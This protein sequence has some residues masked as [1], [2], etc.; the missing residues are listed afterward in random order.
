MRISRL[1]FLL[2]IVALMLALI[3]L[4]SVSAQ[5]NPDG[6]PT[7]EMV[8]V[9]GSFQ[10]EL[11][12]SGEWQPECENT[13]L[14]FNADTGLWEG[15]FLIPAG[16]YEYKI[17]LDGAWDRNYGLGGEASGPNIPLSL[18]EDTEVS[19]SYDH[20]TGIVTDSVNGELAVT[21]DEPAGL[22]IPDIVNIPGTIQVPRG[23]PEWSPDC[24]GTFLAY[25]EAYN[26]WEGTFDVPAGNYMYKVAINGNWTEN[27]GA[28]A[29]QGG[30][31]IPLN[32][33]E[34]SSV[35]FLY[36][37]ETHWIMDTVRHDIIT[38][39]GSFQDEIGC[40]GEWQPE[41]LISWMQ[42]VDG[43]GIYTFTT[44]D[45]PA[46][47]YAAKVTIGR[48]WD[49]NYGANGEAGGAD[50]AF[51]VP[52][53]GETVT[54]TYDSS[55][56]TMVINVGGASV[57]GAN[58]R[59]RRAHWVTSNTIAW[60]AEVNEGTMY[61]LLYSAD[62]SIQVSVFGMDGSYESFDLSPNVN[63]L[64]EAVLAKFPHLTGYS[65]FTLG[66]DAL[67]RLSEILQGQFAIAAYRGENL[68]GLAGVQIPGVLDE[69]YAY[70]GDLGLT[71]AEDGSPTLTIWAPTAR[72]VSLNLYPDAEPNTEPSSVEMSRNDEFGTWSVTGTPDWY[73]QYYTFVVDVF[74][75]TDMAL[76]TNEVTDPYSVGLA[77][78]STRS[79]IIN[80]ADPDFMPE[81][82]QEL[83]KPDYGENFEDI[84]I[85]ELHIRDFSVF[86]ETVPEEYRGTYM[87]FTVVDS[88]G[89]KHL[90]ALAEA[91]LT[92]L[93]LLPSFDIATINENRSRHFAPE[94]ADFEG[95][96]PDSPEQQA[97]LAPIRDLDGFNWGYDPYHFM[98]PEGSYSTDA[99]GTTRIVEYRQMVMALN[100]AGLNVV[101]DVVF[102][103]TNAS[104]QN[105]RSVLDKLVPGYY[106]RLD[107]SGNV[108]TSTCCQNT[109]TEHDMMRRLMVD[110][111]VLEAKYYKIDGFRFDL[112]GHH[113]VADMLAVREALDALTL[114]ADGVDGSRIYLYGEGWNFGEVANNARGLHA[115]QFNLAGTGIGTF[116]DRL[117]DGVRGGSPFGDRDEQG[118]GNGAYV[119]PNGV[120]PINENLDNALSQSDL[121]RIGL[122]GNLQT[123]SF[124]DRNGEVATGMDIDY[125]GSPAGYT[126]DPQENIIYIDK[127]DNETLFDSTVYRAPSSLTASDVARIQS[128]STSF[129]M[130]SQGIPFFQAGSDMLRSKS[131]DRD[132]YNSGDWFNRL[133]FTYQ[134]NNFGVGLPPEGVNSAQWPLMQPILANPA[135]VPS[136]DDIML[137][138]NVFRDML[139]VRYSSPLFR[140]T[141]AEEVQARL[142]FLNVGP[143]QI[144]GVIVMLLSDMVGE[145]IDPSH[146]MLAVVFNAT[147]DTLSY[148][149]VEWA[150]TDF[151]LHPLLAAGHDE[152][153]REASFDSAT[154][155]FSVP[156]WTTS[157]FVVL[158]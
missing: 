97:A 72:N 40:A 106:H 108:A 52:A 9:P 1:R 6:F 140:L 95:L 100:N 13:A 115:T 90:S 70:N 20:S 42:D 94:Y 21:P 105:A 5:D 16:D 26:I 137:S 76:V 60:D 101:Q 120:N 62:A 146:Q 156:S 148:E 82:W 71:F 118:L 18:A 73:L 34:D 4:Q 15:T 144:P 104:G 14:S 85:Y 11:G 154:G 136:P 126:L 66:E 65:A 86:D 127:H 29:D 8:V 46:G 56:T 89:M 48:S 35:T 147:P 50:I 150:G 36:D 45:I 113:M 28:F 88:N 141:T 117:R 110:T 68:A 49:V 64:S 19:F 59:E 122:A 112:M 149:V 124:I 79:L 44:S 114:E 91:G 41:C 93:H 58:L 151:I 10:D 78:N 155:T 74:A 134:S 152:V 32:I 116:N 24:E 107:A 23:C 7:P 96:P 25:N 128:V 102:N 145:N 129:V 119:L 103:H 133:D 125:N 33:A 83:A 99:D 81:G 38:A 87:A 98:T 123:Y 55:I 132:S 153:A 80:L 22:V 61:R 12:C 31:D 130:Y 57:T 111:V 157:V 92:H 131:M 3:G 77:Q 142:S 67:G 63:G 2:F 54:F 39:A 30:P 53:D 143:E 84:T 109:A 27:Y 75:P 51:N 158:E 139:S 43:D 69:V 135:L 121:V 138:V 47:D 17:A 37:H